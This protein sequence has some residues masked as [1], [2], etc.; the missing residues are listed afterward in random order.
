MR[1]IK[2]IP[3]FQL[4]T[5]YRIMLKR[6]AKDYNA[7]QLAFLIGA[8]AD[9]V[10]EIE[11]LQ[12][13]FYSSDDLERITLALEESN[14]QSL[15]PVVNDDSDLLVSVHKQNYAGKL[16]YT[17]CRI[18][19]QNEEEELF[20]LREDVFPD[21]HDITGSE[22]ALSIARDAI[23]L[24]IR[25][26][27]FFEAKLPLEIFHSINRLLPVHLNP[28]YIHLAILRFCTDEDK[29]GPLRV[30]GSDEA[31]YRYEEC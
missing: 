27:Y 26:G 4:E 5:I 23:D 22:E 3:T 11:A 29:E 25:S 13:P 31:A 7:E 2:S 20:K 10:E 28:F 12:R 8:P 16:I 19:E 30:V 21:F 17:Y 9:H 24:L 1:T 6:I 14:P 18:D 15:F